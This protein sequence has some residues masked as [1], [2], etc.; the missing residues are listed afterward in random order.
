MSSIKDLS[1]L[2]PI[3]SRYKSDFE[4][5]VKSAHWEKHIAPVIIRLENIAQTRPVKSNF[6]N[7]EEFEEALGFWIGRQGKVISVNLS[8]ALSKWKE[9][10]QTIA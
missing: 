4:F 5:K 7:D 8:Q 3:R 6:E 10:S 2:K 1:C 9:L